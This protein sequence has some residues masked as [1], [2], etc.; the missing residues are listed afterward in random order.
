MREHPL[1]WSRTVPRLLLLTLLLV[2]PVLL[3]ADLA[4]DRAQVQAAWRLAQSG[5]DTSSRVAGLEDYPLYPYLPYERLRRLG[6]KAPDKEIEQFLTRYG[7][8]LPGQRLRAQPLRLEA[9]RR[10]DGGMQ[11]EV[12]EAQ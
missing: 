8:T 7:D 4:P 9:T 1:F 2:A 10:D 11:L 12:G 3:A 6:A 5:V